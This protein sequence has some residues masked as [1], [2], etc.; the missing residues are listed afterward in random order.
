MNKKLLLVLIATF[1]LTSCGGTKDDYIYEGPDS[2]DIAIFD[3]ENSATLQEGL[4]TIFTIDEQ[5]I[6]EQT[7]A[8]FLS[9]IGTNDFYANKVIHTQKN[10]VLYPIQM[11]LTTLILIGMVMST[12]KSL[13]RLPV[14]TALF[15]FLEPLFFT[16]KNG[17]PM[18][19]IQT[20]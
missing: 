5:P 16:M 6:S 12:I 11:T 8:T 9:L 2:V 15:Q 4:G 18:N 1:L 3:Y 7:L 10:Q 14:I 19:L 20:F 17:Q 13:I